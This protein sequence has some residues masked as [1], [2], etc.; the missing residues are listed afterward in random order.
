MR[1]RAPTTKNSRPAAGRRATTAKDKASQSDQQN[2]A[3]TAGD[4]SVEL[5][6]LF[7]QCGCVRWPNAKR[8]AKLGPKYHKGHEVRLTVSTKTELRQVQRWLKQVGLVYGAPYQKNLRIVQ[9]IY[10]RAAVDWFL[11]ETATKP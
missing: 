6:R 2:V 4:P 9:P 5:R 8:Q 7:Q 1:K 3:A 11:T 10:G